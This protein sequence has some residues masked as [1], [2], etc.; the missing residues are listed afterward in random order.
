LLT[1]ITPRTNNFYCYQPAVDEEALILTEY[2]RLIASL[3]NNLTWYEYLSAY[4]YL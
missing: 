3:I 4:E 1:G 2:A